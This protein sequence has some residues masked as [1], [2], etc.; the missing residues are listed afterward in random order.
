LKI[1]LV[2]KNLE[3]HSVGS[4][5]LA[6]GTSIFSDHNGNMLILAQGWGLAAGSGG[7][8]HLFLK[9]PI[10]GALQRMELEQ[11][12]ARRAA[13]GQK[14]PQIAATAQQGW[15]GGFSPGSQRRPCGICCK[16]GK[17]RKVD[18]VRLNLKA[19]IS[20]ARTMRFVTNP[21]HRSPVFGLRFPQ[22]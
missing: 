4:V 10:S 17:R 2:A 5:G 15:K 21:S 20:P 13:A 19:R 9:N 3:N 16:P 18:G 11:L 12:G 7:S 6:P 8:D 14:L 22:V 1:H